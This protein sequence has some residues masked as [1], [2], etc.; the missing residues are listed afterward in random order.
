MLALNAIAFVWW[1]T[2]AR[3][4]AIAFL[5]VL[6]VPVLYGVVRLQQVEG[7]T[8]VR[9]AAVQAN[10]PAEDKWQI[11]AED[12]AQ[13]YLNTSRPLMGTDTRLVVWPETATPTALRY[14]PWLR[15]ALQH[16]SDSTGMSLLTG[17]T[18]YEMDPVRGQ[19]P[20]NAAF[21]I[22]PGSHDLLRSAKIHLVPF[23]ERI[24]FQSVFP[25]L[26]KL[27]LGQAEWVPGKSVVVFPEHN[28]VPP[29]GCLICYEVIFPEIAS[30]MVRQGALLLTTITNDGWYGN[31]SGPYQHLALA[32]LR[33]I[34]MRRSIVRAANT[35]ISALIL[36]TGEVQT[37]LAYNR[38]GQ[39]S[40]TVPARSEVTVAARLSRVWLPFYSLSLL[41]MIGLVFYQSRRLN[42]APRFQ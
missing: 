9:V 38:A 29:F 24:P 30:D 2:R 8:P 14:R 35:G 3:R 17:A 37:K 1:T 18:D 21:L 12:I 41:V 32:R 23:G 10:T 36:P 42:T 28:G 13:S 26:S 7:G 4:P 5:L 25:F 15:N 20:F 6:I 33:A 19:Q 40:G 39:I 31:S 34:S 27:H 11:P 22:R 16:F